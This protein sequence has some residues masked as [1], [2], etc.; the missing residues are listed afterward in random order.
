MVVFV[1][2]EDEQSSSQFSSTNAGLQEFIQWYGN[3]RQSVYMASIVNVDLA[4]SVCTGW[5]NLQDVGDRY[6]DAT[7]A[8]GGVVVAICE[9]DWS[10]G[11]AAASSQVEP[12]E[13]W[14]LTYTPIEDT[15]IVFED[16]VPMADADWVYNAATNSVEFLAVPYEGALV[17]IGYV[18]DYDAGDDDDSAADDDDSAE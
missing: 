9:E 7:T 14:P 12:Y 18:I 6:I 1:S 13:E 15:L 4:D 3:Q 11:V 5:T 8:F 2:D 17:E 10:P 16:G